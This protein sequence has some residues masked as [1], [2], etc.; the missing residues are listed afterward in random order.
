[1][2]DLPKKQIQSLVFQLLDQGLLDRTPGDRPVLK[3]NDLSW[4]VLRGQREAKLLKPK[5]KASQ[6]NVDSESWEGVDRDLFEH[7]RAWRQGIAREHG[8]PPYVILHDTTLRAW[9]KFVPRRRVICGKFPAWVKNESPISA[10]R[11]SNRSKRI[12]PSIG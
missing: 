9:P 2:K 1:M 6:S 3:L 8:V 4:Q 10:R 7:L 12:V 11:W 5:E